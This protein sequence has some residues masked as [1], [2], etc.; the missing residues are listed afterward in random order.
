[1]G[2][3]NQASN[4]IDR[5]V[6][7]EKRVNDIWKKIG[8][9]SATISKGGLT[10]LHSAF[11]RMVLSN[12]VEVVRIGERTYTDGTVYQGIIFRRPD[13]TSVFSTI[14]IDQDP[15]KIAWALYDQQNRIVVSSDGATGGLALPWIPIPMYPMFSMPGTS[16]YAYR[17][18]DAANIQSE[19]LLWEGCIS[20]VLGPF[21]QINGVWG[22][23]SGSNQTTYSVH[24]GGNK[25]GE[26][27]AS[28][29]DVSIVGPFP[30]HNYLGSSEITVQIKAS[31]TGTGVVACSVR[32]CTQRQT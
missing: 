26:W 31:A 4:L 2:V 21:L 24:V 30:I 19:T 10:L 12:D 28:S 5:V 3:I 32:S 15:S 7:V 11:L 23:A 17:T 14:P 9:T 8:L 6:R 20:K 25:I 29:L 22:Q 13:N 16:L 27:T 18:I 1:M